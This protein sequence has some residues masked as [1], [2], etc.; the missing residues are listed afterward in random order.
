MNYVRLPLQKTVNT[1]ELGGYGLADGTG[2]TDWQVFLRS[3]DVSTL[4]KSDFLFLEKYGIKQV[5]DLRSNQ[6]SQQRSHPFE[7]PFSY[8]HVPLSS[9][10]TVDIEGLQL[11]DFSLETFYSQCLEEKTEEIKH[12]F[13]I[14]AENDGGILFHCAAGKDRTGIIAALLLGVC[15]VSPADIIANYQVSYTYLKSNPDFMQPVVLKYQ[16]L[17]KSDAKTMEETLAKLFEK[18]GTIESYLLTIGISR[19]VMDRIRDK[20]IV[21]SVVC[22]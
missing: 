8:H 11:K 5:I 7:S 12:I 20:F 10:V 9:D 21:K 17:L 19:D 4:S 16:E 13:E 22:Q 6:E 1:R 15:G 14:F 2:Y 3:D 18:Y